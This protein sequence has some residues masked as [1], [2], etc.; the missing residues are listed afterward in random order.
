MGTGACTWHARVQRAC[1][2][3]RVAVGCNTSRPIPSRYVR[4]ARQPT[5]RRTFPQ[6]CAHTQNGGG[7]FWSAA[8]GTGATG[9]P[10]ARGDDLTAVRAHVQALFTTFDEL[11]VASGSIAQVH[12]ATLA[13]GVRTEQTPG[14]WTA[15]EVVAVKVRHPSVAAIIARDFTILRLLAE[16][17][18]VLPGLAWMRLDESVRQFREPL[19]EQVDLTREAL[20]LR[21][22]NANFASWRRVSFP[23]PI[24]PLVQPAVLVE[25]FEEGTS[26][27]KFLQADDPQVCV[28]ASVTARGCTHQTG[29]YAAG[30]QRP[31]QSLSPDN[32][33]ACAS[34]VAP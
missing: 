32:V 8:G 10:A 21:S 14:S 16:A 31:R 25:S 11:P 24:E 5:K 2:L 30:L 18:G 29:F 4:G 34:Y 12:R 9:C 23:R 22:F 33:R 15:S 7:G 19:F 17:A 13:P 20:N 27:S 26:I 3:T 1:L 6:L 28:L